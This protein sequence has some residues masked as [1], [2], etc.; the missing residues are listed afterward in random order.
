[1]T[2]SRNPQPRHLSVDSAGQLAG[3]SCPDTAER[4]AAEIEK[5]Q[6]R[7]DAERRCVETLSQKLREMTTV[8]HELLD[9]E[10][11]AIEGIAY[12]MLERP[13][14]CGILEY[15]E[16]IRDYCTALRAENESLKLERDRHLQ[17]LLR[18]SVA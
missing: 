13:R 9:R 6:C 14:D 1:M 18:A 8:Y 17:S 15:V 4:H 11:E 10:G 16:A 12:A 5:L 2:W 7:I 3:E